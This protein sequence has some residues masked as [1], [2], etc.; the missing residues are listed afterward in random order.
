[1]ASSVKIVTVTGRPGSGKSTIIKN[2]LAARPD[3][4]IFQ[5]KSVTTRSRAKRG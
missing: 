3:M 1:M 5:G 4:R 2:V